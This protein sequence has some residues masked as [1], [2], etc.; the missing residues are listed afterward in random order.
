MGTLAPW[1]FK[2]YQVN[3]IATAPLF[4]AIL[5]YRGEIRP[6]GHHRQEYEK[7]MRYKKRHHGHLTPRGAILEP[8]LC[9]HAGTYGDSGPVTKPLLPG[10][11]SD[12]VCQCYEIM[13]RTRV[14]VTALDWHDL[15]LDKLGP[16][17]FV[18]FDPPYLDGDVRSYGKKKKKNGFDHAGMV[19]TLLRARFQW[20]LSEYGHKMYLKAF[21]KPFLKVP[22]QNG[23]SNANAIECLWK[24]Y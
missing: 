3:D 22:K 11:Y 24:N 19:E 2:A 5:R 20:L 17:S 13:K 1:K 15:H 18:Y 14:A 6:P 10:T 4:E 23:L 21:G 9:S 7:Y 12:K 8:Y 16:E